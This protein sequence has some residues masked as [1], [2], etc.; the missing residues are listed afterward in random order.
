MADEAGGRQPGDPDEPTREHPDSAPAGDAP[1]VGG[2]P[3]PGE[4]RWPGGPLPGGADQPT[5]EQPAALD[6][7]YFD[8]TLAP[9]SDPY[10]DDIAVTTAA[11]D[12]S[13]QPDDGDPGRPGSSWSGRAGV[14]PPGTRPAAPDEEWQEPER[15]GGAWYLPA[16]VGVLLALLL[17]LVGLG[18]WLG[19]KD[20]GKPTPTATAT[21]RPTATTPSVARTSA[22]PTASATGAPS[23][24]TVELPD[25]SKV[26]YA[27][28]AGALH[29]LG[30]VAK[31]IDEVNDS[32]PEGT[33]IRTDPGPGQVP[34]GS[35]V[36]LFVAKPAPPTTAPASPTPS[37]S[38]ST[39]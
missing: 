25:L 38:M 29:G 8:P 36:T 4:P 22:K 34:V 11:D 19:L 28:A 10:V 31:R 2:S 9:P 26:S 5:R 1:T 21:P 24:A 15:R 27:D 37:P 12:H 14:P 35:V 18:L 32:L 30:L 23:A 39:S 16:L 7:P 6:E 13:Y 17:G 3:A 33:V 20:H